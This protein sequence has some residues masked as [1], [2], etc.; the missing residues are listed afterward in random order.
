MARRLNYKNVYMIFLVVM[1][2]RS[3]TL[4]ADILYLRDGSVLTGTL[5][6]ETEETYVLSSASCG[7]V[8]VPRS[9][10]LYLDADPPGVRTETFVLSPDGAGVIARLQRSVPPSATR[11]G[12][13]HLLIPGS[14]RSVRDHNGGDIPFDRQEIAGNSLITIAYDRLDKSTDVLTITALQ[15]QLIRRDPSGSLTLR[16]RYVPDQA[17]TLTVTVK[18]PTEFKLKSATPPPKTQL[19]GLIVW[20]LPLKRQQEFNPRA[21]LVP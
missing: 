10:V 4:S 5:A 18:Y 1:F 6:K 7:E 11:A 21:V 14:V 20:E 2:A 3:A 9:E 8:Q 12:S 13:F 17:E 16:L 19:D 15:P